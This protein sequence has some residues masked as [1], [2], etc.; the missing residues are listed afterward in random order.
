MTCGFFL[1]I[2]LGPFIATGKVQ[3]GVLGLIRSNP[4]AWRAIQ[5]LRRTITTAVGRY[6]AL[7]TSLID[8]ICLLYHEGLLWKIFKFI[9]STAAWIAVTWALA[10]IIEVVLLPEAEAAQLLASFTAWSVQTV[11]AGLA[12]SQ[13]CN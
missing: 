13:A 6:G 3:T 12:V 10:K 7:V 9:L 5:E 4:R 11:E 1:A 8:V 2:G